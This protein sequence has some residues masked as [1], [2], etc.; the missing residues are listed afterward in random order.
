[1]RQEERH[2]REIGHATQEK[3]ANND[4]KHK[5]R[6]ISKKTKRINI[7]EHNNADIITNNIP[8]II[9]VNIT[10][11]VKRN[12]TITNKE[13]K[14]TQESR[15]KSTRHQ[16]MHATNRTSIDSSGISFIQEFE[17]GPEIS[18][19]DG[20][21]DKTSDDSTHGKKQESGEVHLEETRN[22]TAW[23]NQLKGCLT[24]TRYR[25]L[26]IRNL[27]SADEQLIT[28]FLWTLETAFDPA[29]D[30]NA[31]L[32][33]CKIIFVIGK[34]ISCKTKQDSNTRPR[35]NQQG[36]GTQ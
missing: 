19:A 9:T 34:V 11:H 16:R 8:S 35:E 18:V 32:K 31:H 29:S 26:E 2:V 36:Q 22:N 3:T 24:R 17:A 7:I 4:G 5:G 10:N 1:M 14:Q 33:K 6:N 12:V 25:R 27:K 20:P 23:D 28:D 30:T 21:Q 13:N 15:R